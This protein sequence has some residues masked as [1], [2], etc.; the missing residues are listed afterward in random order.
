MGMNSYQFNSSNNYIKIS[1]ETVLPDM[2]I[3][4]VHDLHHDYVCSAFKRFQNIEC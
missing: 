1:R 2:R 4:I 3:D